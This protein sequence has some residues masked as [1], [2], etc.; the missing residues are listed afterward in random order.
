VAVKAD[1]EIESE[2]PQPTKKDKKSKKATPA[3]DL[4]EDE[5]EDEEVGLAKRN[6]GYCRYYKY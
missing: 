3:F 1:A 6:S 5:Q 2:P 4:L